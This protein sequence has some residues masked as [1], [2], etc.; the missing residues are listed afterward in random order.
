MERQLAEKT[1]KGKQIEQ[2]VQQSELIDYFSLNFGASESK[3]DCYPPPISPPF[4]G[5]FKP[6]SLYQSSVLRVL[7]ATAPLPMLPFMSTSSHPPSL[8]GLICEY[9]K[10]PNLHQRGIFTHNRLILVCFFTNFLGYNHKIRGGVRACFAYPTG[11]SSI[12]YRRLLLFHVSVV[13]IAHFSPF[14]NLVVRCLY[15]DFSD[16]ERLLVKF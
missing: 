14:W 6:P 9:A 1:C 4:Y 11:K 2:T 5:Y 12:K 13:F 7:Q 15:A 3:V 8:S 10:P 16:G